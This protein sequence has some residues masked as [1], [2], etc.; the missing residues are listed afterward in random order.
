MRIRR[1]KWAKE[2]LDASKI[3]IHDGSIYRN[4]WKNQFPNDNPIHI[5][6]GCGKGSFIAKLA[7]LNKDINYIAIDMIEAMIGIANRNI[8]EE[9][10]SLDLD[11]KNIFLVRQNVDFINELFGNKDE[12][13]RIYINFCNPWPK[14]K[15]KKRRLTFPTKLEMYKDFL[16][17]DGMIYFKT[18]DDELFDESI[19]YF[20][21]NNFEIIKQTR[22]L[23][24]DD[25]FGQNIE[26]EHEIMF[27][28]KDIKIKALIAKRRM[29]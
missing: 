16:T 12:I 4:K 26:T 15:H 1:K 25:I 23:Q 8:L 27:K 7:S 10:N 28:S 6:L 3:Y 9:Y 2:E 22:D 21:E 19:D 13:E 20:N 5:E 29:E 14:K 24:N 18:D 11:L 17:K